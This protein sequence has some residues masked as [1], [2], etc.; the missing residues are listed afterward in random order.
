MS[1][2]VN[3]RYCPKIEPSD[4]GTHV[5]NDNS[6]LGASARITCDKGY[7]SPQTLKCRE[8]TRAEGV[9]DPAPIACTRTFLVIASKHAKHLTYNEFCPYLPGVCLMP[10]SAGENQ[11]PFCHTHG[12]R[13]VATYGLSHNG[14]FKKFG[15][16]YGAS[17]LRCFKPTWNPEFALVY[18]FLLLMLRAFERTLV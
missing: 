18:N 14:L 6:T 1:H 2:V 15:Q 13:C 4:A 17:S 5:A 9:W 8:D 12:T 7:E 16:M 10:H 3:Q 11:K